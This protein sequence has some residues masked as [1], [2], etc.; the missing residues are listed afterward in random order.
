[1]SATGRVT[2]KGP[3]YADVIQSGAGLTQDID[4]LQMNGASSQKE[5][6]FVFLS[7]L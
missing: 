5:P 2:C 4:A 1:M 3:M 7:A 6:L